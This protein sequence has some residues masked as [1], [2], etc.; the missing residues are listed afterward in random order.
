MRHNRIRDLEAEMMREVCTDVKIEPPLLPLANENLVSGNR[1]ENARLDVSGNGIWGPMQKT[2][3]D[4]R[5]MHPNSP[6]YVNKEIAQVYRTHER[7][8]KRTYNE[9]IIQVEKGSFTPIVVSTFGGMGQEAESFHKR[10]AQLIAEKR[11]ETYSHVV[12]YIRTRLRFC[13]LKS[14]LTSLRGVRG[15]SSHEKISPISN[16]SFNL[17]QFDD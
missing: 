4:I 8:K 11:N 9:R 12:N 2:F 17:I 6:T 13:L 15:K 16:L 14:V 1:A 10:L 5:V 3:L 7:E